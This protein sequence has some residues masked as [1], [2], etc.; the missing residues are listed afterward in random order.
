MSQHINAQSKQ[1]IE[2]SDTFFNTSRTQQFD[3]DRRSGIDTS[4]RSG[5]VGFV[6]VNKNKLFFLT[7]K[8]INFLIR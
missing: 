6:K 2:N 8:A 4:H 5:K 1:L 7:L 3:D